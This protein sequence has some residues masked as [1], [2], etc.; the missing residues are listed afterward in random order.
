MSSGE[1]VRWHCPNADCNTW[2]VETI[3][4]GEELAPLCICGRVMQKAGADGLGYLDFLKP[5][6]AEAKAGAERR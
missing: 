1:R 4:S 6:T 2:F 3:E 5:G